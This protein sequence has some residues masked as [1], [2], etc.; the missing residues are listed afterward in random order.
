MRKD[1]D[2]VRPDRAMLEKKPLYAVLF[3]A[4]DDSVTFE[5][6]VTNA[7]ELTG[8]IPH[9]FDQ[10]VSEA[11]PGL[12]YCLHL[13]STF[14]DLIDLTASFLKTS[15]RLDNDHKIVL[16][17]VHVFDREY[18]GEWSSWF[19]PTL[20]LA[21]DSILDEAVRRSSDLGFALGAAS[22][23]ELANDSLKKH[24]R[25]IHARFLP[26]ETYF[27]REPTLTRRLDIAPLD[28]PSQRLARQMGNHLDP[29]IRTDADVA[30]L[31]QEA[32]WQQTVV[33]AIAR[34][35]HEH[36]TP[37]HADKVMDSVLA[38]E[39][40]RLKLPVT[41]AAP[42]VAPAYVRNVYSK[43]AR[44][45]IPSLTALD[46]AD[47]WSLEMSRRPDHLVERAAIEFSATHRAI[48]RGGIGLMLPSMPKEAFVALAELERHVGTAPTGR[49]IWTML[50]R[51]D[52]AANTLWTDVVT[53]TVKFASTLTVFSNFPLGLLRLPGDTAPLS[54]RVPIA[55]RPLIP[56]TRTIQME[57]A[58]NPMT[59]L[60][61][62]LRVLVAEC[63]PS[64]DPVGRLSRI[65]WDSAA[66]MFRQSG[67]PATLDHVETLSIRAVRSAISE[68]YPDI[69]VVSAHGVFGGGLYPAGLAIGKEI[70]L[71][72][73][74]GPLPP[75][76]ILSACHVSPRGTGAV[77][78]ADMLFREGARA[79]LGT[80]VPVDVG[81][82]AMLMVRFFIY[83]A[84]V[85]AGREDHSSLLEIWH[86]VQASNAFNDIL[87]GNRAL[88]KWASTRMTNGSP[89]LREFMSV[90]SAG[91]LRPN[92]VYKDTEDVLLEMASEQGV[93]DRVRTWLRSPGYTPESAFYV[94]LGT[95]ERIFLRLPI[96]A[97]DQ[98][99]S[100]DDQH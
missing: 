72:P 21:P 36:A 47:T 81:R 61:T 74:L 64:S 60:T 89:V 39:A 49:K 42:G 76:V 6:L 50:D 44:E 71:G 62:G 4:A 96:Q 92:H 41:I 94:F 56:L 91:R 63:I 20:V 11:L 43:A 53:R 2:K 9:G 27:A 93:G 31:L 23:S 22:F 67:Q 30:S 73:G 7:E 8:T 40:G 82:N 18:L 28:L 85:L 13:P 70:C 46:E 38:E 12:W 80:Q 100:E 99:A 10:H 16:A 35:E 57:L 75:V 88:A 25:A 24:W 37:E 68:H 59:N 69:L 3:T 65:G 17:P 79:V 66:E 97:S 15:Q 87:T 55:Y 48:G 32:A 5:P 52:A 77:S 54:C 26:N 34:L 83:V 19:V 14:F 84:E 1:N 90:R 33:A 78:V 58:D 86:R 29:R 45:G 98:L 95:P 51:L